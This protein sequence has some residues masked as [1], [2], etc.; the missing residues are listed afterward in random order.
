MP[1]LRT[2][3]CPDLNPLS[4]MRKLMVPFINKEDEHVQEPRDMTLAEAI[5]L[6]RKGGVSAQKLV[7]SCL[8]RIHQREG[9]IHAWVELYE[10]EALDEAR[11]CDDESRKGQWRGDLHGMPLGVKDI[12]HVKGMWT[13]AGSSIYPAHVAESDAPIVQRLRD[14][15]A[16]ILGKTET[17]PFATSDPTI[18]RNPWNP[19]HTPGGSSSGSGAA[20]ADRMCLAA[21]GSQTTGSVLRPAA[22]NGIV[23]FK[24]T[25]GRISS[26]G[27]I[28]VSW[29]LDHM[30]VLAR[31]VEDVG[32]LWNHIR[33]GYMP[34]FGRMPVVSDSS[35]KKD[36]HIPPRLGHIRDF[37]EKDASPEV[38]DHLALVREK[39][40]RAGAI[41]SELTLPASFSN[42]EMLHRTIRETDL[43]C[44]HRSLFESH[45]DKYPPRLKASIERGLTILGH[46][47]VE[48]LRQRMTIQEKMRERLS[49]VDAAFMPTAQST[50]PG[51]LSS[52]GSP[53]FNLPWSFCGFPA[54]SIPS[55]LD[56]HGLPFGLQLSTSPMAEER[57]LEVAKWCESVLEFNFSPASKSTA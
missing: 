15:G 37:F 53:A 12:L 47:Y 57:L 9:T 7:E 51:G 56:D 20:V 36:L 6:M 45:R 39:F 26:E 31:C 16:I 18:T 44:Y 24:G 17:T 55:G 14:A 1:A 25:Y 46:H 28:P 32:I 40:E 49:T 50:A 11:R 22:F 41:V 2:V 10:K 19:E 5:K 34:P 54:I 13:R 42:M 33:D 4:D 27:V 43:A 30:G 52:T 29:S 38:V 23:G 3:L 8:E 48:A 35:E 21:L